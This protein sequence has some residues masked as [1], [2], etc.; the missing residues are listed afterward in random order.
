M[1]KNILSKRITG[2]ERLMVD[3]LQ[4]FMD[5]HGISRVELSEIFGVTI[6]AVNLWMTGKREFTITNSRLVRLFEKYPKLLKEF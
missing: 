6:Q 5:F 1:T 2:N 3:E 4:A